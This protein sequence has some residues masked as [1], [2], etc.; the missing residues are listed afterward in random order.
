M[1]R[2]VTETRMEQKRLRDKYKRRMCAGKNIFVLIL[3]FL[4]AAIA[5]VSWIL[6]VVFPPSKR[7]QTPLNDTQEHTHHDLP[8]HE[9]AHRVAMQN[10]T[11]VKLLHYSHQVV[12]TTN[13]WVCGR[14]PPHQDEGGMPLTPF[15]FS[16]NGSC[17]AWFALITAY[18]RSEMPTDQKD[19]PWGNLNTVLQTVCYPDEEG[20]PQANGTVFESEEY[21]QDDLTFK[22]KRPRSQGEGGPIT[23]SV[24]KVKGHLCIQKT[25]TI[26]VGYSECN[27]TVKF[28]DHGRSS[29]QTTRHTYFICGQSA[30]VRLPYNWGGRCY[31]SFLLPPVFLASSTYHKDH[32]ISA[33]RYK[34]YIDTSGIDQT[35]TAAEQYTDFNRGFF[36]FIGP[37]QNSKLIRRLTRTVEAVVNQTIAALGNLTQEQSAIRM[38][39]LQNRLVL[40]VILA[41]KGGA[42]K[43]IGSSCCIFI[44]DNAPSVYKAISKLHKIASGL[45]QDGFGGWYPPGAGSYYP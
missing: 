33:G 36:F 28:T 5:C 24:F 12:N 19:W 35:E 2:L 22:L 16:Y 34:R 6:Y 29:F 38:V 17:E 42:C 21:R 14:I 32:R 37:V 20:L 3:M 45:H 26:S 27:F 39:A 41:E 11:F 7:V 31:I 1:A 43:I 4:L 23:I 8:P 40:D 9:L 25:G 15:P 10:N 44:P 30:Y 18:N 13:C